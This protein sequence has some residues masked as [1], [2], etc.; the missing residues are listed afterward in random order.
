[1]PHKELLSEEFPMIPVAY[2]R[3]DP[4]SVEIFM[5]PFRSHF[6]PSFSDITV[7]RH[8]GLIRFKPLVLLRY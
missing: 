4:P 5:V 6:T 2:L 3:V 1:M 8:H 7:V